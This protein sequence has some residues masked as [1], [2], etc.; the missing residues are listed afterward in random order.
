MGETTTN[1]RDAALRRL[2]ADTCMTPD[3]LVNVDWDEGGHVHN[4]RTYVPDVVMEA[5]PF[6]DD[7]GRLA[8]FAIASRAADREEWD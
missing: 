8:V 1:E 3:D 7:L 4:W 5:W 6:M 2:V